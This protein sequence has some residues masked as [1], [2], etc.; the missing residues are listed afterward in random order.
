MNRSRVLSLSGF[1][2]FLF[3]A[4][5]AVAQTPDVMNLQPQVLDTIESYLRSDAVKTAKPDYPAEALAAGAQGLVIVAVRFDENSDPIK[6]N[7]LQSP[8]PS[9]TEAVI[10]AVKAWKIGRYRKIDYGRP[11]HLQGELRFHFIIENAQGR[12]EDPS[13][14]EMAKPIYL[15]LRINNKQ[16]KNNLDWP[17]GP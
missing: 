9:I 8:H 16:R 1:L 5:S 6:I 3:S 4:T 10:K 14:E 15:Y 2:L 13:K 11:L 12:V 17:F 7:V